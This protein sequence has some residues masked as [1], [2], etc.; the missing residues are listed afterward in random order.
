MLKIGITGGIG[1]GKTTVCQVFELLGV[2]VFYADLVAK[3]L[4]QSDLPLIQRVKD[5]FGAESYSANGQLDRK[6]LASKVFN[7]KEALERLNSLVHPAVFR[8]FDLWVKSQHSAYVLKEAALLFE[9][10]SYLDCDHTI[11]VK[12]PEHLRIERV[13]LRDRLDEEEIRK[14]I[15]RQLPD[16]EKE[17]MAGTC[18]INDEKQFL[19]PHILELHQ[20]FLGE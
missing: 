19:I 18:L 20:R 6:Y 13:K 17:M 7:D 2:P 1:S 8:A 12:A 4:M 14:R 15:R 3:E 16:K 5:S 9:S 10:K 11:L